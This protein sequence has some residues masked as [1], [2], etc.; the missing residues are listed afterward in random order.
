MIGELNTRY[1]FY[2]LHLSI[3]STKHTCNRKYYSLVFLHSILLIF[4]FLLCFFIIHV[5]TKPS[6]TQK[7][8]QDYC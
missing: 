3:P 1:A 2:S 5:K 8:R 6:L 4:S 7:F